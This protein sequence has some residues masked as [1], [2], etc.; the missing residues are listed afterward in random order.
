V[1]VPPQHPAHSNSD[2]Q[3]PF[4]P[5]VVVVVVAVAAGEEEEDTCCRSDIWRRRSQRTERGETRPS[6]VGHVRG[7]IH[8]DSV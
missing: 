2:L 3:I 4:V 1:K 7:P 8:W 6:G 5:V